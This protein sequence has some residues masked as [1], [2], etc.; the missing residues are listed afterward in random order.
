M[1]PT[2]EQVYVMTPETP[3]DLFKE[4]KCVAYWFNDALMVIESKLLHVDTNPNVEHTVSLATPFLCSNI[5]E[6]EWFSRL[7]FLM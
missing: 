6:R 1:Y 2:Q 3:L 7:Q 5:A 4:K